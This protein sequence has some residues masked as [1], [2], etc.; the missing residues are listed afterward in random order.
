M[1]AEHARHLKE[2]KPI[3]VRIVLDLLRMRLGLSQ[4]RLDL[5]LIR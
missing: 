2:N 5:L 1:L 4:I 3:L